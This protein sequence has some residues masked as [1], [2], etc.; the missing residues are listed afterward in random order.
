MS[1]PNLAGHPDPDPI[2]LRELA[3]ARIPATRLQERG[4]GEV[5]YTVIGKYGPLEFRRAWYYWVVEGPVPLEVA[6]K[7]YADPVGSTDIRVG[8][9]CGCPPPER[10]RVTWTNP[11]TGKQVW[12]ILTPD[13]KDS[14]ATYLE[15]CQNCPSLKGQEDCDE[16]VDDPA[17]TPGLM[18]TVDIY[19]V[20][21]EVGLRLLIDTL[22]EAGINP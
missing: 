1:L 13:G 19:H 4:T 12:S 3:R 8:G 15:A 9:D 11:K 21:T 14:R 5:K 16:W 17:T 22:R 18:G 10:P 6:Q 7:L 2:I 20:D